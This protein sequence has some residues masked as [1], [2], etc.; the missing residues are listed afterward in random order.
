VILSAALEACATF[1]MSLPAKLI[2]NLNARKSRSTPKASL[3]VSTF[4]CPSSSSLSPMSTYVVKHAAVARIGLMTI[5]NSVV[6]HTAIS[7]A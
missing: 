4:E 7:R 1:P 5:I 6:A 3:V 2:G